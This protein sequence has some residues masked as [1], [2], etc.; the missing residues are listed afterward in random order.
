MDRICMYDSLVP[1]LLHPHDDDEWM[2]AS[3]SS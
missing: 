2:D 1:E 3:S